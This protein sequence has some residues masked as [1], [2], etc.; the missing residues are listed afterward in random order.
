[1]I[2]FTKLAFPLIYISLCYLG[3]S[4]GDR[5]AASPRLYNSNSLETVQ[6]PGKYRLQTK[7]HH[8]NS[9]LGTSETTPVPPK[10]K[11]SVAPGARKDRP[12]APITPKPD[13]LYQQI[14]LHS[15]VFYSFFVNLRNFWSQKFSRPSGAILTKMTGFVSKIMWEY[16]F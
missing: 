5:N 4:A 6:K 14:I 10:P 9:L 15:S 12:P 2:E 8:L 7:N 11:L 16:W 3:N 13:L 1:M